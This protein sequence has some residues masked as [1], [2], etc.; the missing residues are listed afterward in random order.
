MGQL[1]NLGADAVI[2]GTSAW[3]Q[4]FLI[5]LVKLTTMTW[6][7]DKVITQNQACSRTVMEELV[8][9]GGAAGW[10]Q[11][12]KQLSYG[13]ALVVQVGTCSADMAK[14]SNAHQNFG[15]KME[16]LEPAAY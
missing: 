2:T 9:A 6:E 12:R 7:A 4:R 5:T 3:K 11:L 15:A 14:T 13:K 16:N 1:C 10:G 8:L